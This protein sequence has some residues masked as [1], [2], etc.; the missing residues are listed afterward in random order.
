MRRKYPECPRKGSRKAHGRA[1][2]H[3]LHAFAIHAV[4]LPW[5]SRE[6]SVSLSVDIP[7]Y[8]VRRQRRTLV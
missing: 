8:F 7:W 4:T 1:T 5:Y 3:Q 6:P 2:A